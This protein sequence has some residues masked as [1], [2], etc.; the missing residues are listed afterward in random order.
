MDLA[1][2]SPDWDRFT[3]VQAVGGGNADVPDLVCDEAA[4]YLDEVYD[5]TLPGRST[6]R[7]LH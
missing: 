7:I 4:G 5:L 6:K 1:K 3:L 2:Y